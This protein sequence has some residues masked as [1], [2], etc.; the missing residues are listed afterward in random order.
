MN[1]LL[2]W[3]G[4]KR[5]L[6]ATI[7]EH[8]PEQFGRYFEPLCGGSALFFS[9][10][11]ANAT[12]SDAN[13]ELIRCYQAVAEQPE[14]II[15]ILSCI[16]NTHE[17]YYK[18]RAWQPDNTVQRAAKMLYLCRL[19]FNG[20]YRVNLRG[21]YNVPYGKKTHLTSCDPDLIRCASDLLRTVDF[22]HGDFALALETAQPGDLVYLD[23][24]YT[25]A[26]SQNGFI[27]YNQTLFSWAD[28]QRLAILAEELRLRGCHVLVSNA[29]HHSTRD[30]YLTFETV[31]ITRH[32]II[33]ASSAG[34]KQVTELLFVGRP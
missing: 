33:S 12:L 19:S 6:V 11:A 15:D 21:E 9:L 3:P 27:K 2:K 5:R 18:I 10:E 25:V 23:P 1:P 31:E 14:D 22:L 20:I 32:S 30:L 24:P 29:E 16:P 13:A 17:E 34:R 28:Q 26:H 7:R 8:F 4:G